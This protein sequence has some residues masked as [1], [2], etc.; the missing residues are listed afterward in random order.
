MQRYREY[1]DPGA[2]A[3]QTVRYRDWVR[4]GITFVADLFLDGVPTAELGA[5]LWLLDHGEESPLRLGA[6]KPHGFGVLACSLDL[7]QTRVWNGDAVS[8]GWLQLTRPAPADP[9][10]LRSIAADFESTAS[11]HPTLAEALASYRAATAGVQAHPVHYPRTTSQHLGGRP[12][13]PGRVVGR[14]RGEPGAGRTG[15][16]ASHRGNSGESPR[17]AFSID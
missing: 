15:S 13:L 4:P 6:G 8:R 16:G 9:H 11:R 2:P 5:L 17:S 7:S 12:W 3:S 14:D 1:L 10:T